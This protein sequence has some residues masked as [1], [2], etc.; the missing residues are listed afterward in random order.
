M[1]D[2]EQQM[3]DLAMGRMTTATVLAQSVITALVLSDRQTVRVIIE[4]ID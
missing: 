4:K 3:L 1:T 2:E